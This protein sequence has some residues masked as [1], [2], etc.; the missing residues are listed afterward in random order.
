MHVMVIRNRWWEETCLTSLNFHLIPYCKE[1]HRLHAQPFSSPKTSLPLYLICVS[2]TLRSHWL[3]GI[4][5]PLLRTCLY[6]LLLAALVH[7]LAISFSFLSFLKSSLTPRPESGV[8]PMCCH[9]PQSGL[10]PAYLKA[11]S[12]NTS[13]TRLRAM[14]SS[15]ADSVFVLHI[16]WVGHMAGAPQVWSQLMHQSLIKSTQGALTLLKPKYS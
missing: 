13:P 9:G 6:A 4:L 15:K 2:N 3:L 14:N 5:F 7:P 12:T 8:P 1:R 16:P 11:L 10:P